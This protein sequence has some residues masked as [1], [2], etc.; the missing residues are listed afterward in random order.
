MIETKGILLA[1]VGGQGILRASDILCRVFM[2]AGLDV[3]KSEVHGMAQRGGC[4]TSHVRYGQC[5]HSPL[6]KKHDIQIL[7]SFERMDTLRYM[8]YVK[9]DGILIINTEEIYP[10]AINQ[11]DASYPENVVEKIGRIYSNCRSIDAMALALQAGNIRTVNA[12][13]LGALSSYLDLSIDLWQKVLRD[14]FTAKL[15][16]ANLEAFKLGR[17]MLCAAK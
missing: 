4:V 5:V 6:S 7:L 11:G 17:H 12:V 16:N 9:E 10:P 14:S 2:E 13:M 1:G 8:D 3:K 15:I